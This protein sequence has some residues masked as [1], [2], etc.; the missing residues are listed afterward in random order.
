MLNLF[1]TTYTISF[2]APCFFKCTAHFGTCQGSRQ[3]IFANGHFLF[4]VV[5]LYLHIVNIGSTASCCDHR[6]EV[7]P[8]KLTV[9]SREWNVLTS[10]LFH[11]HPHTPSHEP[12]HQWQQQQAHP[13]HSP[14]CPPVYQSWMTCPP[15]DSQWAGEE[16]RGSWQPA[17]NKHNKKGHYVFMH[18][19]S[20]KACTH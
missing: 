3:G 6:Q 14:P 19:S 17:Q 8:A 7:R 11:P 1:S 2:D 10:H 16:W 13:V 20:L 12:W 9:T 4:C 15:Y 18:I 5:H